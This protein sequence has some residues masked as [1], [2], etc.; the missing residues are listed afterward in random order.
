MLL[1]EST[2]AVF[3]VS[4]QAAVS[5]VV[6]KAEE[7]LA[8]VA[9]AVEEDLSEKTMDEMMELGKQVYDVSC[10]ACHQ[11]TGAGMPPAFPSLIGSPLIKGDVSAHIDMVA[12]GSKKNPAMAAFA[13]QLT[14]Q[15]L[16]AVVTYERNAWGNNSGDLVQATDVKAA[17]GK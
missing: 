7:K 3:G 16:A 6:E 2:L 12:N 14:L 17:L 13:G 9:A 15:Q 11:P 8:E 5:D 4:P 10:A 1:H